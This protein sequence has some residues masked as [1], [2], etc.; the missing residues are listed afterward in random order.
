M[1]RRIVFPKTETVCTKTGYSY[2][3]EFLQF[4]NLTCYIFYDFHDP[5][6]CFLLPTFK[7]ISMTFYY[8]LLIHTFSD[9]KVRKRKF[10]TFPASPTTLGAL[11]KPKLG[12]MTKSYLC[13]YSSSVK[14]SEQ[15]H[16]KRYILLLVLFLGNG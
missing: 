2:S 15:M 6:F 5:V 8:P 4:Y 9:L 13:H 12:Q 3:L 16:L 11:K 1:T 7:S 14:I 10:L